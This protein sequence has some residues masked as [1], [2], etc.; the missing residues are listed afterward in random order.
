MDLDTLEDTHSPN[1]VA[2]TERDMSN[3]LAEM[4]ARPVIRNLHKR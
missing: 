2:R 4:R 3:T 1:W